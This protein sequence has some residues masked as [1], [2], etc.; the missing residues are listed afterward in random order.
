[1]HT[2]LLVEDSETEAKIIETCLRRKG[3]SVVHAQTSEEA[4]ERLTAQLPDLIVL[5]IILPGKSGFELCRQIKSNPSTKTV[6]II[7]CSTKNT[8]ADRMWGNMLGADAYLGKPIDQEEMLK[9]INE[10][11]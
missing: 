3:L 10:L 11:I 5:D 9:I 1:M 7:M 2:V 6:P 8:D 4:H